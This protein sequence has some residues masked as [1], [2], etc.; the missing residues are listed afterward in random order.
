MCMCF[1]FLS[2]LSPQAAF[3]IN[4]L[5]FFHP[6][7]FKF[8]FDSNQVQKE[9]K[10]SR[11]LK[12]RLC[13]WLA[14]FYCVI[15]IFHVTYPNV[16]CSQL[17]NKCKVLKQCTCVR[18]WACTHPHTL[19]STNSQ[20]CQWK[21]LFKISWRELVFCLGKKQPNEQHTFWIISWTC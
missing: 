12:C 4:S 16:L 21:Y 3:Q 2:T 17:H 11:T 15:I 14:I 7:M 10:K 8:K 5:P 1:P 18:L 6:H 9:K 20:L 19:L 13:G